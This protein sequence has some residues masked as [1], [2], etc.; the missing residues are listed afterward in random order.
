MKFFNI[1]QRF[2]NYIV[3]YLSVVEYKYELYIFFYKKIEV[4]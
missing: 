1:K 2:I 4:F 3:K